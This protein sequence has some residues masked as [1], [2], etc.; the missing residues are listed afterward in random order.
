MARFV[1]IAF[2]S[3]VCVAITYGDSFDEDDSSGDP[4]D[5]QVYGLTMLALFVLLHLV[6]VV[7]YLASKQRSLLYKPEGSTGKRVSSGPSAHPKMWGLTHSEIVITSFDDTRLH[8][9]LLHMPDVQEP[10]PTILFLHSN[11]GDIS[12]RLHFFMRLC[13]ELGVV[14]LAMEYRGYGRSEDGDGIC[15]ES[16]IL[17]AV[18]TY[19][20]LLKY[21]TLEG[22]VADPQKLYIF[23]RSLGGCVTV[24]LL[25]HLLGADPD[26]KSPS[27]EPEISGQVKLPLPAGIILENVPASIADVARS[28]L[29]PLRLIPRQL[30]ARP[31]LRDEWRSREWLAWVGRRLVDTGTSLRLCMLSSGK[32][33]VVP[34]EHMLWLQ[35]AAMDASSKAWKDMIF[36]SFPSTGHMDAYLKGGPSYWQALHQCLNP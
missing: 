17:D 5:S 4:S 33:T 23:G 29:V 35:E 10:R 3:L 31:L 14:I 19:S 28:L 30:L 25:A 36:Q 16:F 22:S 1:S 2:L 12:Q 9:W 21:C 24:R 34:P 11:A 20:W 6:A 27:Q 8:A 26:N 7:A 32:D 13:K 18:A 15:E